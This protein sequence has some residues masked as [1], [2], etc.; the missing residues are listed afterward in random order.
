MDKRL[1]NIFYELG[2]IGVLGERIH[3]FFLGLAANLESCVGGKRN[4]YPVKCS[5]LMANPLFMEIALDLMEIFDYTVEGESCVLTGNSFKLICLGCS[6]FWG[7]FW[8][9]LTCEGPGISPIRGSSISR[10]AN[11]LWAQVDVFILR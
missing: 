11:M 4:G 3:N 7:D 8:T 10:L 2:E 5:R 1:E 9:S 6:P